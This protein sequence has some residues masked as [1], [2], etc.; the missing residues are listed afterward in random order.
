MNLTNKDETKKMKRKIHMK[1]ETEN[2][3]YKME[4][5]MNSEK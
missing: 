2:E 1:N 4:T 3:T 5:N